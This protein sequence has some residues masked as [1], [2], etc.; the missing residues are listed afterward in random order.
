MPVSRFLRRLLPS[1]GLRAERAPLD[2]TS[3]GGDES[4]VLAEAGSKSETILRSFAQR[5]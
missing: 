2:P 5:E 4:F 3:T 1:G